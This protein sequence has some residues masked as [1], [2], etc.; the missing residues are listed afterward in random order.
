MVKERDGAQERNLSVDWGG[1]R[2]VNVEPV[3]VF[4]A[5]AAPTHHVVNFGFVAPPIIVSEEDRA[6]AE[7]MTSVPAHVVARIVLTPKDMRDLA[8]V[9]ADNIKAR[10]RLLSNR[11]EGQ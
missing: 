9:L 4:V 7:S 1:A 8:K 3:N 2:E 11:R 5:Q 10:E 6:A